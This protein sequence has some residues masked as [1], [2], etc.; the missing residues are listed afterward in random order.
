MKRWTP[1]LAALVILTGAVTSVAADPPKSS[2]DVVK[3]TAF[4]DKPDADG[5]QTV[6]ITL[7]IA[8]PWHLYANPVGNKDFLDTQ[9]SVSVNAAMK[10][11]KVEVTFP[12]GKLQKDAVVGDYKIYEDTVTITAAVVRAKGDTSPLAIEVKINACND[13]TCLLPGKIKLDVK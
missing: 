2:V 3:A 9:T 13:N 8:K 12:A 7:T 1:R 4:A 5:K 6:A 10:P 11:T